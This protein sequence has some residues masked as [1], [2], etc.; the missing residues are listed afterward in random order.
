MRSIEA[1]GAEIN[2]EV[3]QKLVET[4][5]NLLLCSSHASNDTQSQSAFHEQLPSFFYFSVDLRPI[6]KNRANLTS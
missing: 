4:Y 5:Q 1:I 2:K 3:V 6:S